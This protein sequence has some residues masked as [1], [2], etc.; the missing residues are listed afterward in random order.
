MTDDDMVSTKINAAMRRFRKLPFEGE[1]GSSIRTSIS[2]A[3]A[4]VGGWLEGPCFLRVD[5]LVL[6]KLCF[7][8]V[9][10]SMRDG[11]P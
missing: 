9:A 8:P 11:E 4:A 5:A 10:M 7:F 3:N 1:E 2:D 6:E